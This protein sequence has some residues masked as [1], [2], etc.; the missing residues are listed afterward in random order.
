MSGIIGTDVEAD[1]LRVETA[2]EA[3][4]HRGVRGN[5]IVETPAG[6]LGQVWAHAHRRHC[7]DE[8]DC[9]AVLDGEI[10]NWADLSPGATSQL[11][12]VL[13]AYDERGPGF[14]AEID[15]PFAL[16]IAGRDGVLLARD[17]LGVAPLYY[18][19]NGTLLFASEAK[20]V[21]QLG[22]TPTELPPGHYYHPREGLVQYYCVEEQPEVSA[23]AED[24]ARELRHLLVLA[25]AKAVN[26]G[27]IGS[28][29][30]GGL[31]S[32][33]LAALAVRQCARLRTFAAGFEGSPDIEHARLVADYLGTEHHECICTPDDLVRRLPDV[34]RA[35]ESFDA[36]LVRSSIMNFMVGELAVQY[37]PAVLSGEGGDELF[38]GYSYLKDLPASELASELVDIIGR[39]HNTALQRV[40]RCSRAHG[41]VAHVPFLDRAVVYFA[42]QIPCKYKLDRGNG[43][44]KWI[45]RRAMD[46]L[47]PPV[48]LDRP[49]A[50]FWE[51]AGVEDILGDNA[52]K[53]ISDT[54]FRQERKLADGSLL[55]TKEELMYYRIFREQ[56]GDAEACCMVGRTKGAPVVE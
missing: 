2:L 9:T 12:A 30:S 25:V 40:D 23:S 20:A 48:I 1:A 49:K 6:T 54:E 13:Q 31:D 3:M 27:E 53:T 39:L 18:S 37:V 4:S 44:E 46:G 55:N 15:G 51:G 47:L 35:L 33:T 11:E 32:S 29:L 22:G 17:P 41:L 36:L 34:I 10:H 7:A 56:F 24:L 43:V 38:A 19:D 5:R 16:A 14:V 50:K 28:W 21:Q 45:L 42:L 8:D 52:E 26:S